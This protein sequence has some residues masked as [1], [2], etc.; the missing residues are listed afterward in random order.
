[1]QLFKHIL[2]D[3]RVYNFN[4]FFF[5]VKQVL[6][7]C[8]LLS[9]IT[10]GSMATMG[11]LMYG[12]NLMSQITLNLP[13]GKIS[14]KIAIHTTIFN[15]ITKYALVV[16]PIATAIEDKLPLRKSKHIVSYFIRSFLVISTV[17]VA[18]TVP[19]FE[20]VMTFTG[21][22]LG[23]TVSILLPCLCYL[24]IRKPSYLEVVF[25]GMILVFGSLVAISGTYTSLKN[26]ISHL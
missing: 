20:Y 12:Q 19:F 11:Y 7:V 5:Y 17:I 1:M 16:S 23:V 21:A 18:L 8:F 25:I 14:S 24:K 13:T 22:L 4:F 3:H 26:I 15:P 9:T 6:F 2:L 10:Y